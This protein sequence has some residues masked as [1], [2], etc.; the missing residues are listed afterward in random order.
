[1]K[2]R[3]YIILAVALYICAWNFVLFFDNDSL[4]KEEYQ[5]IEY[6]NGTMFRKTIVFTVPD[7]WTYVRMFDGT[8]IIEF[9]DQIGQN[10]GS[11][12]LDSRY[13]G[14]KDIFSVKEKMFPQA[15]EYTKISEICFVAKIMGRSNYIIYK[16]ED[17]V[18]HVGFDSCVKKAVAKQI[19]RNMAVKEFEMNNNN[20]E[21][22]FKS[23][24]IDFDAMIELCAGFEAYFEKHPEEEGSFPRC[25]DPVAQRRTGI[26]SRDMFIGRKTE[27]FSKLLKAMAIELDSAFLEAE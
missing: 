1:M 14:E 15:T 20:V 23:F 25:N 10:I 12:W 17:A 4:K 7:E 11:A 8:N 26:K 3:F 22:I 5:K 6:Q 2:R 18:I 24:R 21:T 16:V 13:E 27:S 9:Y 19:A